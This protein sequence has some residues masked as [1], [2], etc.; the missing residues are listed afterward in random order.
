MTD[1]LTRFILSYVD[2]WKSR[3]S[4][5]YSLSIT[6][7]MCYLRNI[8]ILV[9]EGMTSN[10]LDVNFL[11]SLTLKSNTLVND[12]FVSRIV[13]CKEIWISQWMKFSS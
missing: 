8:H 2:L 4:K 10:Y 13:T 3:Y 6:L 7:N 5:L 11:V 12:E 1:H 9:L